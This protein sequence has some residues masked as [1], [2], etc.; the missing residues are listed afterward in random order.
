M[1]TY[2]RMR[3]RPCLRTIHAGLVALGGVNRIINVIGVHPLQLYEHARIG[4]RVRESQQMRGRIAKHV[5]ES[6]SI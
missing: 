5:R 1:H 6:Q 3:L 2:V 4:E